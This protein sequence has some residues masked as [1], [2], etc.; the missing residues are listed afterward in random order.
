ERRVWI[1]AGDSDAHQRVSRLVAYLGGE[2]DTAATPEPDSLCLALPLGRDAT[3]TALEEGLD[4]TRTVA[5]D[6]LIDPTG[7][8]PLMPTPVP[9]AAYRDAAHALFARGG[10]S[11]EV[12]HDSPGFVTQRVLAHIV[13]IACDIAQQR[14]ASPADIDLAVKLGLNYPQGPLA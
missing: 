10:R 12:I 8:C 5:L 2:P 11:V 1:G 14:V 13:N 9:A 7:Q 4:P 6:V 3:T